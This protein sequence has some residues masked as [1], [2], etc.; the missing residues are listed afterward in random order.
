MLK[1]WPEAA[2]QQQQAAGYKTASQSLVD[3]TRLNS[4]SC[5]RATEPQG[6][7]FDGTVYRYHPSPALASLVASDGKL[8]FKQKAFSWF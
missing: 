2:S 4:Q 3:P 5:S 1:R 8:H 6:A 7:T